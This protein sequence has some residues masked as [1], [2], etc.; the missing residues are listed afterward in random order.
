MKRDL[1]DEILKL[2]EIYEE[3]QGLSWEDALQ[4]AYLEIEERRYEEA[5][6]R[7]GGDR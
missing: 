1:E 3:E 7:L 4:K 5:E 2:A 6:R